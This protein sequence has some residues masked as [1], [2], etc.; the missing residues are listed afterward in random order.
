[1]TESKV[2]EI[3]R[4][5]ILI[6][7]AAIH[8]NVVRSAG[9]DAPPRVI[10]IEEFIAELSRRIVNSFDP[11]ILNKQ[12]V[13]HLAN[14]YTEHMIREQYAKLVNKHYDNSGSAGG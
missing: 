5:D 7:T 12:S 10:Y 9:T 13:K 3:L 1:M 6:Y 2:L 14:W 8:W 4:E 11:S